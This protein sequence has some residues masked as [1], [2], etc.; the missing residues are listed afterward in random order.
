MNDYE[1][2]TGTDLYKG[3]RLYVGTVL[4]IGTVTEPGR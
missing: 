2:D 4:C 3:T 1:C